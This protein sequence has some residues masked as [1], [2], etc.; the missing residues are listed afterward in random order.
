MVSVPEATIHEDARP[1]LPHHDI[2]M[3]RQSSMIQ[4]VSEPPLPEPPAH[5]HLRLRILT[6]DRSHVL[7]PLCRGELVHQCS[8]AL[9]LF[10]RK[11]PQNLFDVIAHSP[12]L[13]E[14][15]EATDKPRNT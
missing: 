15:D 10:L 9:V 5:N 12:Y 13:E 1:V 3:P 6:T 11:N 14:K 4:P 8:S 7:M 2:R